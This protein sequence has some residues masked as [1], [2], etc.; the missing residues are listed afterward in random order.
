M[1]ISQKAYCLSALSLFCFYTSDRL[2]LDKTHAAL[3]FGN[4]NFSL[5]AQGSVY[6]GLD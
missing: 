2:D 5:M 3:F 1:A 4:V 6:Q